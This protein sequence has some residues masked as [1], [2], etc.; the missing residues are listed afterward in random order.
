MSQE[1]TYR[2]TE[3]LFGREFGLSS[4]NLTA[5]LGLE[6]AGCGVVVSGRS[7]MAAAILLPQRSREI[8]VPFGVV[9]PNK[10]GEGH[11]SLLIGT[12]ISYARANNA[13]SIRAITEPQRHHMRYLLGKHGF[14]PSER[15][16]DDEFKLELR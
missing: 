14:V 13:R 2:G 8:D 10:R 15:G 11:G 1:A 4:D 6:S 3:S 9:D 7:V 12:I 16:F 5:M